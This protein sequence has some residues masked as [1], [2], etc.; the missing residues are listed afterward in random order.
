MQASGG[1]GT[2]R[3]FVNAFPYCEFLAVLASSIRLP[4]LQSLLPSMVNNSTPSLTSQKVI[5]PFSSDVA[6][7]L[8][9]GE[10]AHASTS[11]WCVKTSFLF[12]PWN[13]SQTLAVLSQETDA[14]SESVALNARPQTGPS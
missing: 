11:V 10:N 13:R 6:S 9:F 8:P 7:N 4:P 5:V 14:R 12:F 2:R 1:E 3:Y